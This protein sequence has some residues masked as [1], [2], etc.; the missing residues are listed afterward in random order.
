MGKKSRKK[1]TGKPTASSLSSSSSS[2]AVAAAAAVLSSA[3]EEGRGGY[4]DTILPAGTTLA[5]PS[6]CFHGSNLA[7]FKNLEYAG[8]MQAYFLMSSDV[9]KIRMEKADPFQRHNKFYDDHEYF[10]KQDADFCQFVFA[11]CTHFYQKYFH[12]SATYKRDLTS[13]LGLGIQ[14]RYIDQVEKGVSTDPGSENFDK[15]FKYGRDIGS[16][17]GIIKCL[18]R[19]IPCNCMDSQKVKAQEMDKTNRC[20]GCHNHFLKTS[21]LYCTGCQS[22]QYCSKACQV[23]HWPVHRDLCKTKQELDKICLHE[24]K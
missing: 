11:Y 23:D 14:M 12:L 17:R 5:L 20:D 7:H 18:A 24:T 4:A 21:L 1:K 22:V 9:A 19:E 6:S 16:E 3:V 8:V 15:W 10:T 13:L 2:A